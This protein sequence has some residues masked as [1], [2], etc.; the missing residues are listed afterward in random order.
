MPHE[1]AVRIILD[2]SGSQLDP[3]LV[4]TFLR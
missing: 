4:E 3:A 2:A 1:D